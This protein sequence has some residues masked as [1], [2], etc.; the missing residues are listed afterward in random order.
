MIS[1]KQRNQRAV[2]RLEDSVCDLIRNAERFANE[3][4]LADIRNR[5]MW[6]LGSARDY[7]TRLAVVRRLG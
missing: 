1:K 7:A 3:G 6:L 5:R 2:S 4:D